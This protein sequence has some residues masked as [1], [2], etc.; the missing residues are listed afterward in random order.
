MKD[1]I[2]AGRLEK[3]LAELN[4]GLSDENI[5]KAVRALTTV[6]ASNLL[7]SNEQIHTY[8]TH[9]LTLDQDG[10]GRDVF[11]IDYDH[12]DN[13]EFIFTRQFKIAGLK[14]NI[15][16]GHLIP[17]GTGFSEQRNITIVKNVVEGEKGKEAEPV[18]QDA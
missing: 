14:E 18:K 2:L 13:N 10:Q 17:A 16:M 6:G 9:S 5:K 1:V 8:L 11:F 4:T 12:P 15:I 3:K 7:E